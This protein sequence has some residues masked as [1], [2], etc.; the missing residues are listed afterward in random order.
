MNVAYK[1]DTLEA[2]IAKAPKAKTT[3]TRKRKSKTVKT[4]KKAMKPSKIML[5]ATTLALLAVSLF[6]L[7]EG[8]Q[9]LTECP[10]WQAWALAIGIDLMFCASEYAIITEGN[11][12]PSIRHWGEGLTAMTVAMSAGLNAMAFSHNHID[13]DHSAAAGFG[14]FIPTAVYITTQMLGRMK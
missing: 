6:H 12:A 10:T 9:L 13:W 11:D 1:M 14:I 7:A 8:V 3:A 4:I 5:A 2:R